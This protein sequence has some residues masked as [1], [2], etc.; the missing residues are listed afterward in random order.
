MPAPL[1]SGCYMH[2]NGQS[3][4]RRHL[5]A[6]LVTCGASRCKERAKHCCPARCHP[7]ASLHTMLPNFGNKLHLIIRHLPARPAV[8][9]RSVG[10]SSGKGTAQ[11]YPLP[12]ATPASCRGFQIQ[13]AGKALHVA[14]WRSL[15]LL[16]V[17]PDAKNGQSLVASPAA[18]CGFQTQG[19]GKAL[20]LPLWLLLRL[21]GIQERA[22]RCSPARCHPLAS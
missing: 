7:F 8:L 2:R 22:R 9:W 1:P 10:T 14:V 21:P 13:G 6:S 11:P 4:T 12:S 18:L 15:W 3:L 16:V 17:L 19:T 20:H 5:V